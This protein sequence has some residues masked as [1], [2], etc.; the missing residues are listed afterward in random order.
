MAEI[1]KPD[2][3]RLPGYHDAQL[4]SLRFRLESPAPVYPALE[5][6]RMT[7]SLEQ[8]RQ[9]L[10]ADDEWLKIVL[11]GKSPQEAAERYIGGT[12]LA[13]AA[14]RKELLAGGPRPWRLRPIR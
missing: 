6:A 5:I 11:A 4:E 10:G 12:K 8:A 14:Y 9:E 7:G 2:G 13:D 1:K 3:E